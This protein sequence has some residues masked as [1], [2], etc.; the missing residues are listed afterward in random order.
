M[1]DAY[2]RIIEYLRVSIT[3]RCN[4]RCVYCMPAG[5]GEPTTLEQVL[6]DEE[7]LRLCA[8]LAGQGIRRVKVTGGEPLAR[9]DA[10]SLIQG[11]KAINGIEQVT[12]TSNGVLLGDYLDKLA[13]A[14]LDALNISLD[15]LDAEAFYRIT[16][17]GGLD[18]TLAAIDRAVALGIPVKV[19]C[20]PIRGLNDSE[21]VPLAG[22]AR[23]RNIS[24]RFIELMPMGCSGGF[25]SIPNEE[26]FE[27]IQEA[28]GL[29]KDFTGKLG[30]GPAVYY[31]V[32]GFKGKLGFISALSHEFCQNCNRL[33]LTSD[34]MLKPCLASDTRLDLK[35][36]LRTGAD[37]AQIAREIQAFIAQKPLRHEFEKVS[38]GERLAMHSIGG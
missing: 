22:L 30:N 37:D 38:G 35:T 26:V 14:G 16:R 32:E 29:L 6:S 11:I 34:G 1:T 7:I 17:S 28:Y 31:T 33:R 27:R 25:D 4:L 19:N 24:V 18:K 2:G 9:K 15:A 36:M 8:I 5:G 21:L 10:A 20:V 12:L 3:D 13:S 23:E